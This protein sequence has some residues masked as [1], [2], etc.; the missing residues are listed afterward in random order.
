MHLE[1]PNLSQQ[2]TAKHNPYALQFIFITVLLDVI[3]IGI[4][5]P[6]L[7]ALLGTLGFTNN[8]DASRLGGWLTFAFAGMQFLFA[9][10]LGSLSDRF[11]RRPVLLISLAGLGFDYI[12]HA[13]SNSIEVLFIGRV[14]AGI[15]GA[16]F[17][18]A[19]AY[20]ADVSTVEKRAQNFGLVGAA[21]GLGFIIGPVLGGFI[22]EWGPRAPFY[23]AAGLSLLNCIY[24]FFVLPESLPKANRRAFDIR[25]A[26]P[27]GSLTLIRQFPQIQTI[28]VSFFLLI[29]AGYSVQGVWTFYTQGRF[30]WSERMIGYSLSMVGVIAAVV[31]GGL[32]R[33]FLA[34][35]GQV[36]TLF[37]ALGLSFIGLIFF[38]LANVS[39]MMFAAIVPYCTGNMSGPVLQGFVSSQVPSNQQ[40]ALQGATTSLMSLASIVGP[41]L[42]TNLYA[43]FTEKGAPIILPGAPFFLGAV[44]VAIAIAVLITHVPR[45]KKDI[46]AS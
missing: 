44:L 17:T 16:S 39:W 15:C 38:G 14:L 22:G 41:P 20:I 11:G 6:V 34:K 12:L 33:V 2:V 10:V 3:G 40:G 5:I 29:L 24:G 28:L 26:N 27:I 37:L 46:N 4:I 31:Q 45:L 23:V 1:D 25:K 18:T 19:T 30:G 8:A 43:Y 7:P 13:L 21:F 9:P 36:N 42:M 35:L 32:I